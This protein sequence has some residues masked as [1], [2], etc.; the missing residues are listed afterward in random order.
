MIALRRIV[1]IIFLPRLE[2]EAIAREEVS[3]DVLLR[4]YILPLSLLA[5]LA[6]VIG[7]KWFDAS[8]PMPVC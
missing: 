5:P 6:T 1:R 8:G 2:W 7:M 3:V 4:R